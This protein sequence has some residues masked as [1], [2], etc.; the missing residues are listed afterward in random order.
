M[1]H[2]VKLTII[3]QLRSLESREFSSATSQSTKEVQTPVKKNLLTKTIVIANTC[4]IRKH[5]VVNENFFPNIMKP[6]NQK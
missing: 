3:L 2:D 4:C 5:S 1:L 6:L